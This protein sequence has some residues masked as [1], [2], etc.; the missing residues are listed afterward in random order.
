L[1]RLAWAKSFSAGEL[2]AG[3][4]STRHRAVSTRTAAWVA[5]AMSLT[6]TLL[7]LGVPAPAGAAKASSGVPFSALDLQVVDEINAIR[8]ARGLVPLQVNTALARAASAHCQQLLAGGYFG[9]QEPNGTSFGERVA[10]Y[11]PLRYSRYYG[12]GENL[13]WSSGSISAMNAVSRWM[14]SAPHRANILEPNWRQV[15]VA[16]L[17]VS[18]APGI[19]RNR[20]VTVFTVDFG[21]RRSH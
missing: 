16:A 1:T 3:V 13:L 15:G 9:H 20:S 14:A 4:F 18:S 8:I 17:S 7:V 2:D 19:Y 5:G 6:A 10:Y 12:I 21:V 11:Y